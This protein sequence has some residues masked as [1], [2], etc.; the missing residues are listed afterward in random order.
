MVEQGQLAA[1]LAQRDRVAMRG[2]GRLRG[3]GGPAAP[4]SPDNLLDAEWQL[5]SRPTTER[6][7]ADFRAVPT[8]SPRGYDRLIDQVVLVS[9]LREVRALLGFTRVDAPERDNLRP[10]KRIRLARGPE[11]KITPDLLDVEQ[12][13]IF[14]KC[15]RVGDPLV[16]NTKGSGLGLSLVR[17]IVQA[18]GGEVI[19]DSAP[20]QG[21]K[22]T[23]T[24][25]V[26]AATIA[27]SAATA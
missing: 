12:H 25:P 18:H 8:D 5:L 1:Q 24:L 20:G 3:Q 16:H 10:A 14:E 4:D 27:S 15:Y 21:S 7:D 9:R 19:V 2:I 6:Q 23:I 17:H 11:A 26:N 22:F 13:K